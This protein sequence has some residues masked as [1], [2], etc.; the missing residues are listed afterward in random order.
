MLESL[1]NK[2]AILGLQL[3]SKETPTQVIS[4]EIHE[5]FK[6]NYVVEHLRTAASNIQKILTRIFDKQLSN[7]LD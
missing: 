7:G 6:N 1:F 4:C 2:V 3:C 5:I